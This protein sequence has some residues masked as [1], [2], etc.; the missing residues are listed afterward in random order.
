MFNV[1]HV[2]THPQHSYPCPLVNRALT[3]APWPTNAVD[4]SPL[5]RGEEAAIKDARGLIDDANWQLI[6]AVTLA[7]RDGASWSDIATA[8]GVTRQAAQQRFGSYRLSPG[9]GELRQERRL[10][11]NKGLS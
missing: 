7:R 11:L 6:R 2:L 1:N 10:P 3:A 5:T 9:T 8:L 4:M